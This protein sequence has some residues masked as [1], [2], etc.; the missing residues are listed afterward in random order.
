[1][2]FW[3]FKPNQLKTKD[4]R[5]AIIA[6]VIPFSLSHIKFKYLLLLVHTLVPVLL[7]IGNFFTD[8]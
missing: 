5:I 8:I 6:L 3:S 2:T 4:L 1:V 7:L